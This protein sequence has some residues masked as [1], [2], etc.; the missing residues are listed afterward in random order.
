MNYCLDANTLIEA[1]RRYYALDTF[2]VVWQWLLDQYEKIGTI[3][4]V[5]RELTESGDAL[6]SWVKAN[7]ESGFFRF[8]DDSTEV[9]ENYIAVVNLVSNDRYYSPEEKAR[10]LSGAD[11]WLIA[12]AVTHGCLLVTHER[13][14]G[15][16][17]KKV[18][19]PNVCAEFQVAYLDTFTMLRQEQAVFSR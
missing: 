4:A 5:Y 18:K 14:V 9:Q 2:P 8:D 1:H 10:F 11:P 15:E 7:K 12:Y 16:G 3:G 6:S 19:I 17:S 13:P